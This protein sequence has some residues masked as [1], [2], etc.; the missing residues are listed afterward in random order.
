ME[1]WES[2]KKTHSK[3]TH[4]K[5][6][7]KTRMQAPHFFCPQQQYMILS[8]FHSNFRQLLNYRSSVCQ[9]HTY[10]LTYMHTYIQ[11]DFHTTE[12]RK[13]KKQTKKPQ[14]TIV[15][16]LLF[17]ST[18]SVSILVYIFPDVRENVCRIRSCC[19]LLFCKLLQF[20]SS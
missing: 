8:L 19:S 4:T 5:K 9:I 11:I 14:Q 1:K 13:K 16:L 17:H 10:I 18:E 3:N 12:E 7:P 2:R 6:P 15:P 20:S